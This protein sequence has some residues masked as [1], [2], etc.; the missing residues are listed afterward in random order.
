VCL[1]WPVE[2]VLFQTMVAAA[3]LDALRRRLQ[4]ITS[5]PRYFDQRRA[6]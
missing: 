1:T 5:L 2:R 6:R 3:G 4:G